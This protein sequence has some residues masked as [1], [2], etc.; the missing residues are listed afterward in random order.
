M[1]T[2]EKGL[3]EDAEHNILKE[4]IG[5]PEASRWT[6]EVEV[7]EDVPHVFRSSQQLTLMSIASASLLDVVQE[8][9]KE[10]TVFS[11]TPVL[12]DREG[13]FMVLAAKG[14]RVLRFEYD[15]EGRLLEK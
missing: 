13:R 1:R 15:L 5:T 14:G 11:I 3:S 2:A 9:E 6:A 12:E 10:G 4:Y 7:F 8:A